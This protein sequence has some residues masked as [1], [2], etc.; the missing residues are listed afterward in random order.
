MA[1]KP[2]TQEEFARMG[3]NAVNSKY[4][5]ETRSKWAKKGVET[6]KRLHGD[7]YF[8]RMAKERQLAKKGQ[9]A[10]KKKRELASISPID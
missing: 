3:A 9:K 7:D 5:K 4:D 10:L 8:K 2:L 1:S 6:L